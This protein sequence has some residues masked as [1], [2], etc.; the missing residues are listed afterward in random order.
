MKDE[1][2]LLFAAILGAL[3]I[4]Q[5]VLGDHTADR[6]YLM[7][8][9]PN[10]FAVFGM[11]P[12]TTVDSAYTP[13]GGLGDEQSLEDFFGTV[14]YANVGSTGLARPGA[15]A[16]E[17]GLE[18]NGTNAYLQAHRLGYPH[19]S[20]AS[21]IS[22]GPLDYTGIWARGFQLWVYA[23]SPV[24][25][26]DQ[27]I[28]MDTDQHGLRINTSGKWVMT[29]GNAYQTEADVKPNTWH[30]VMVVDSNASG[31]DAN[32]Y[33]YVDGIA[34]GAAIGSYDASSN[35]P[36]IV[37][38][39][40]GDDGS[41]PNLPDLGTQNFFKGV[42]DDLELFVMGT[43]TQTQTDYGIFNAGEDNDY[44]VTALSGI[45]GDVNQDGVL[46]S[47]D[48]DDFI[49]G[50]MV[51]N[52]VMGVLAGDLTTIGFGDLNFDG[53]NDIHDLALIQNALI[54][55]GM[56]TIAAEDLI[57]GVPEP[58]TVLLVALMTTTILLEWMIG[59][60]IYERAYRVAAKSTP[61]LLVTKHFDKWLQNFHAR[62]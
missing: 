32:A 60:C 34:V 51:E 17:S 7:G 22:G 52:R 30:H 59:T 20:A 26:A 38:A 13:P 18:F 55:A 14:L 54:N 42:L 3:I 28:V 1:S 27:D 25:G 24:G 6:L 61:L 46:N 23:K 53:V 49:A 8:D 31:Q 47:L 19:S 15:A 2:I 33:L 29:Y 57:A 48:V 41:D 12:Y 56:N 10:E 9:D 45:D 58:P 39:N 50:W 62:F 5:G 21:T 36:L 16:G 11:P 4:A 43:S 35:L 40:T 44:I 37:G